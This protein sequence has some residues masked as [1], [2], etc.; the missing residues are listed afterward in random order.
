MNTLIKQLKKLGKLNSIGIS[1]GFKHFNN[2]RQALQ[3]LI[4]LRTE[5]STEIKN[6]IKEVF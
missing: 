2:L 5:E 4:S 3:A 1:I 6:L